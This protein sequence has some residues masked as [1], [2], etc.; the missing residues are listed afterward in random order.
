MSHGIDRPPALLFGVPVD[1]VTM[2]EATTAIGRLVVS[3]RRQRRTHQVVTVNV[4]FLVNAEIDPSTRVLL[5]AADLSIADGMPVLWGART[6]GMHLRER[7]SGADLVPALAARAALDG[8]R[9]HL[10][11]AAPGTAE[12]AAEL[13]RTRCPG[14][15]ITAD[16]GPIIPDASAVDDDVL[17]RIIALD[18]DILCVALGNPKQ[19]R[20]IAAN[21]DRL[22]TPVMIGVGGT[23]DLLIG[24]K[25]R[26]PGWVQRIGMEWV[27][28]VAQEPGRLAQR[29][30][31]DARFFFPRLATELRLLRRHERTG[32]GSVRIDI[33]AD[34]VTVSA[35][36]AAHPDGAGW[37]IAAAALRGGTSLVLDLGGSAALVAPALAMLIG[38]V[39]IARREG[40]EITIAAIN[41]TLAAQL[42]SLRL[43][44]FVDQGEDIG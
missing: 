22:R 34:A 4:D 14:A 38:L 37:D 43:E 25:K 41:P 33:A 42:R 6:L 30:A 26:A 18:P 16:S 3:G 7:V 23:F 27:V 2:G 1:D 39:R 35:S 8:W 10:F 21:R 17:T 9:I 28:R 40:A 32:A 44:G 24:D 5:Q 13:L 15:R 36:P 20:F 11:G 31:R 29:Y 12:A 19:E